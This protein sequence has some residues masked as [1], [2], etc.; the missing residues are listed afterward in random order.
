M[1]NAR[2]SREKHRMEEKEIIDN[3]FEQER[4][5]TM[6]EAYQ[7]FACSGNQIHAPNCDGSCEIQTLSDIEIQ[8]IEEQRKWEALNMVPLGSLQQLPMMPGVP[9][10]TLKMGVALAALTE[11]CVAKLG[12]DEDELNNKFREMYLEKLVGL[13]EANQDAVKEAQRMQ[14]IAVPGAQVPPQLIVP[15][16]ILKKMH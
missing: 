3:Q 4:I 8:I 10:D 1:T 9:I 12:L 13:R 11:M 5:K 16:N 7:V 15:D 2:K 6:A 14:D